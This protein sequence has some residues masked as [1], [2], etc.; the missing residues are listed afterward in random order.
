M[1]PFDE[2]IDQMRVQSSL[3][4]CFKF[5]APWSVHFDSGEHARLVVVS[6]GS[7]WLQ[8]DGA[9]EPAEVRAG[10]CLIVQPQVTFVLGDAPNRKAMACETLFPAP[11]FP[12]EYGGEGDL[13]E[14]VSGRF[15]FDPMAAEPLFRLMPPLV[16]FELGETDAALIGNTLHLMGSESSQADYGSGFVIDQLANALFV[17]V[18][19]V[20]CRQGDRTTTCWLAGL[21]DERLARVI[22]AVHADL[23]RRWT[24]EEMA[25]E[26]N[27]SRSSFAALFKSVVGEAPLDYLTGWRIYRARMLLATTDQSLMHIANLVGYDSDISLSR[28]F[29]R[30]TGVAPGQWR[31]QAKGKRTVSVREETALE[32]A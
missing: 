10:T 24:V 12:I 31:Q 7:C 25:R 8:W 19:R 6:Q 3:Y 30:R 2:I 4:A 29:R 28:A 32:P 16:A 1:N 11:V 21:G 20:L 18:L 9:D 15:S 14:I 5:R 17:Q 27:L 13:T 23:G 26:A 22:Q